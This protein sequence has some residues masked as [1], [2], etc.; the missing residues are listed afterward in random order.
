MQ[1]SPD[2]PPPL[3]HE[4]SPPLCGGIYYRDSHLKH[5][6]VFIAM[7]IKCVCC[8]FSS[9]FRCLTIVS[10]LA[11]SLQP[12][13]HKIPRVLPDARPAI[14]VSPI[15]SVPPLRQRVSI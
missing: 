8:A 2:P 10:P 4:S 14:R 3:T 11:F 12:I 15:P 5:L 9:T 6:P 1:V 13:P 7:S